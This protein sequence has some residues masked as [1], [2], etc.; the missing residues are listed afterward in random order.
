MA[1]T[2]S[3]LDTATS[4]LL[5]EAAEICG[6]HA[7]RTAATALAEAADVLPIYKQTLDSKIAQRHEVAGL[8]S[9][10]PGHVGRHSER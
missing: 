10:S 4:A 5:A 7:F 6:S 3:G 9:A 8:I 2:R 1:D